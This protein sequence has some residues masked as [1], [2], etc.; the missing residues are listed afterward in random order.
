MLMLQLMFDVDDASGSGDGSG[1]DGRKEKKETNNTHQL[2]CLRLEYVMK[3]EQGT[4]TI[5]TGE[6]GCTW[7]WWKR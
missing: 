7:Q 5:C 2:L 4:I 6:N 3:N 1:D